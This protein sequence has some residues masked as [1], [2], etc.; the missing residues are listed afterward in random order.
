MTGRS[1]VDVE[2]HLCYCNEDEC[3]EN[4]SGADRV[5]VVAAASAVQAA[6]LSAV[7]ARIIT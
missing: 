5:A 3:N 6:L 4:A 7:L 1:S 2:V